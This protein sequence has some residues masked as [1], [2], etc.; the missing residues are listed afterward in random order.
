MDLQTVTLEP[1][2]VMVVRDSGDMPA[3]AGRAFETLERA[4]PSLKGRKFYGYWDPDAKVYLACVAATADDDPEAMG[5]ERERI[6]GGRYRRA[7]LKGEP[8]AVY[9]RIG[10][11]FEEMAASIDDLDRGRPWIEFYRARDEIDLLVPLR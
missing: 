3:A 11:T 2:D 7:R 6:P 10:K 5:L 1:I 9:E 4:L 8:P